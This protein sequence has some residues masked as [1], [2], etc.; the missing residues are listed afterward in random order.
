MDG[1]TGGYVELL[2]SFATKNDTKN[3]YCKKITY[4]HTMHIMSYTLTFTHTQMHTHSHTHMHTHIYI[5]FS[6]M[7]VNSLQQD[8]R[9]LDGG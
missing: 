5:S 1:H 3:V 6:E 4:I 9:F 7:Q 2:S 8:T